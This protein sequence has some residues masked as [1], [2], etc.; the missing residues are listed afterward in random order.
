MGKKQKILIFQQQNSGAEKAAALLEKPDLDVKWISINEVLPEFIELPEE[1]LPKDI[2]ADLVMDHLVHPD[3]SDE[4]GRRC[5]KLGIPVVAAGKKHVYGLNFTPPTCCGLSVSDVLGTYGNYFGM[6]EFEVTVA[7]DGTIAEIR[8]L[9]EAPCGATNRMMGRLK[10]TDA[11]KAAHRM[12]LEIQYEC[13]ANPAGWDPIYGKSPVHFAGNIHAQALAR[14]L[15]KQQI[16]SEFP[17]MTDE[18]MDI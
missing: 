1:Y 4:L 2:D 3:L 17:I 16:T 10:E 8:L 15:E 12:G 11:K 9:R 13:K 5:E 7:D 6:P 18:E 14:A